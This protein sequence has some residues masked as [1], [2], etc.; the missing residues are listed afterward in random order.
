MN[1]LVIVFHCGKL[2]QV[3]LEVTLR[4]T[5]TLRRQNIV[6]YRIGFD[7]HV[8]RFSGRLISDNPDN[9]KRYFIIKYFLSDDTIAIFELG[10]RNSGFKV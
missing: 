7:S 6:N 10:E 5:R 1:Y 8:L 9:D 2:D 4:R 3:Q